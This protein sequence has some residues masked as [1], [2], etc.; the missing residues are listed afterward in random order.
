M[1][2]ANNGNLLAILPLEFKSDY[3]ICLASVNANPISLRDVPIETPNYEAICRLATAQD[4]TVERYI[5]TPKDNKPS[6]KLSC[7]ALRNVSSPQARNNS[8]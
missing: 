4:Y 5:K 1:I 2:F 3:D 8:I 6:N 7:C